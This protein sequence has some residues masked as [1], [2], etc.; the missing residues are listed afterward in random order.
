MSLPINKGLESRRTG[1]GDVVIT[2]RDM[3]IN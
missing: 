2:A 1:L 3:N